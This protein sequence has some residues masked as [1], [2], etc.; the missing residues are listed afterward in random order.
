MKSKYVW[1][2]VAAFTGA[3]VFAS[4]LSAHETDQNDPVNPYAAVPGT[5]YHPVLSHYR[6]T[7]IIAKPAN[8]RQLNDRAEEINGPR[9]Q[10][11]EVTEPIRKRKKK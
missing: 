9:G 10:L 8:W 4:H 1:A 7:P 2:A 5:H 6:V 3:M 11:R